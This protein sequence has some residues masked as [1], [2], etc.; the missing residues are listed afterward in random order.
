MGAVEEVTFAGHR[1]SFPTEVGVTKAGAVVFGPDI[2]EFLETEELQPDCVFRLPKL[3]LADPKEPRFSRDCCMLQHLHREHEAALRAIS[4]LPLCSLPF[5]VQGL[6]GCSRLCTI[7]NMNDVIVEFLRHLWERIKQ[8]IIFRSEERIPASN[9]LFFK[10]HSVVSVAVPAIWT[11]PMIDRIRLLI[12]RAGIPNAHISSEPKCCAAW[13][14]Y[15]KILEQAG[16][17]PSSSISNPLD[18]LDG[19]CSTLLDVGCGTAVS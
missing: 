3:A 9:A 8:Y 2:Q 14:A 1:T 6:D 7:N 4:E 12:D 15:R 17:L 19:A 10:T 18:D 16:R 11:D 13:V 5:I